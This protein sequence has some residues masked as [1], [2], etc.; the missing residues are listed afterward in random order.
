MPSIVF[1]GPSPPP[2]HRLMPQNQ[3]MYSIQYLR[4][5]AAF[6]VVVYHLEPQLRRMG[7]DGFWPGGLAG[8]VDIFFVISGFIMWMT[9]YGR[10][11]TTLQ[12]YRR[13]IVRIVPLYWL[14]TTFTVAAMLIA[15]STLQ[16]G[17]FDLHH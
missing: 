15:P 7:Y 1:P 2:G 9:T 16:S 4:A 12:F 10:R 17:R 14:V 13:R 5:I 8:G 11:V 3:E 6:S